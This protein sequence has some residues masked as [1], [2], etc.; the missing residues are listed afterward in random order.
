MKINLDAHLQAVLEY[1]QQNVPTGKLVGVAEKLPDMAR[2]L[3]A[4]TYPREPFSA[5]EL[6]GVLE[7]THEPQAVAI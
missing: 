7:D 5:I 1:M 6:R 3:W 2:L 4:D